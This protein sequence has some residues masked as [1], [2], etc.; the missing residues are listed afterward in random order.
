M[1]VHP[2]HGSAFMCM[3]VKS[4]KDG[5]QKTFECDDETFILDA[6]E[7]AGIDLPYS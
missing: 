4:P 2:V 3:Q 5:S 7:E 1:H 6:A